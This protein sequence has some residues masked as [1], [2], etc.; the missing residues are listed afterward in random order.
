M[1]SLVNIPFA[2]GDLSGTLTT[3][4][5][6]GDLN[7]PFGGLTFCYLLAVSPG[8]ADAASKLSVSSFFN[9][10]TDVSFNNAGQYLGGVVPDT[11]RRSVNGNVVSFNFDTTNIEHG[12]TSA[13]L[14]IQTDA[15]AFAPTTVAVTDGLAANV[16]SLAPTTVVPEPS[17]LAL[18][19][20]G[21]LA[22]VTRQGRR[23]LR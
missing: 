6:A 1:G 15:R 17:V 9:F 23:Q 11:F 4:V 10:I 14:V 18:L 5:L 19:G 7:N 2:S 13:L 12:Q 8:A 20:L 22:Y 3:T 16:A 21:L